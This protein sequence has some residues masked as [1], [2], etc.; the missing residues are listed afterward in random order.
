MLDGRSVATH[1]DACGPL[2]NAFPSVKV[3]SDALY[4]VDGPIWT[5]AGVT[6][7][8]DMALAMVAHDLDAAVP[9]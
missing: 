2:A 4:V 9:A 1:W 8:I 3:N 7:G 5:S 6:T